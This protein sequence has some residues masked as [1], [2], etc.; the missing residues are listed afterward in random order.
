LVFAKDLPASPAR[1]GLIVRRVAVSPLG[2]EEVLRLELLCFC[3]D[4]AGLHVCAIH[5]GRQIRQD[6][7]MNIRPKLIASIA[8]LIASLAFA[9]ITLSFSRAVSQGLEIHLKEP[10]V[11]FGT[12]S[13]ASQNTLQPNG[14]SAQ[15]SPSRF[16][17]SPLPARY[18]AAG[19]MSFRCHSCP[20][21]SVYERGANERIAGCVHFARALVTQ[22]R[23]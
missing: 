8:A 19:S 14:R 1:S 7:G 22:R 11:P 2:F 23:V 12:N 13:P 20:S 17:N 21:K 9:W 18:S 10:S 5:K 15:L 16:S 4:L 3:R 6:R